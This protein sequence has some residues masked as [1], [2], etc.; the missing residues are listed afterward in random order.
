MANGAANAALSNTY[1]GAYKVSLHLFRMKT[2]G[3][4]TPDE[5]SYLR[6]NEAQEILEML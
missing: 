5:P 4:S 6:L 3:E 1:I 2:P